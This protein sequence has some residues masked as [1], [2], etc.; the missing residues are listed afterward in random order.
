[1]HDAEANSQVRETL[2]WVRDEAEQQVAQ[3]QPVK[4][5]VSQEIALDHPERV[6]MW[7][8]VSCAAIQLGSSA[9]RVEA[10]LSLLSLLGMDVATQR[11][12]LGLHSRRGGGSVEHTAMAERVLESHWNDLTAPTSGDALGQVLNTW[13]HNT[14]Q[15]SREVMA[16]RTR[17]IAIRNVLVKL[18]AA[19]H[20]VDGVSAALGVEVDSVGGRSFSVVTFFGALW[21]AFETALCNQSV[22]D[23]AG[24]EKVGRKQRY[25]AT[26]AIAKY[27]LHTVEHTENPR[28]KFMVW[29]EYVALERAYGKAKRM[30]QTCDAAM[31]MVL[32]MVQSGDA[33][34]SVSGA[35]RK[36]LYPWT[37]VL[38]AVWFRLSK[39]RAPE[40]VANWLYTLMCGRDGHDVKRYV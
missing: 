6:A 5:I 17:Q 34:A 2:D 26:K 9:V 35:R 37:F 32:R 27:I 30:R 13:H 21:L 14:C 8:D 20:A 25:D 38:D 31:G 3:W 4:L 33:S 28:D 36:E 40:Q 29:R 24:E 23:P 19:G 16:D 1:L 15:L 18:T 11:V 12:S 7:D 22:S 10:C 39:D